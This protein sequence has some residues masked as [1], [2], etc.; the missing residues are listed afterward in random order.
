MSGG[1]NYEVRMLEPIVELELFTN[2]V[3][4]YPES[5]VTDLFKYFFLYLFEI[6]KMFISL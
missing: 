1:V 4:D 5:S 3:W 2:I 6:K